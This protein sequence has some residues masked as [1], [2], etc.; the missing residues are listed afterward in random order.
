M[1][2]TLDPELLNLHGPKGGRWKSKLISEPLGRV[3]KCEFC[4]APATEVYKHNER[5]YI[6]CCGV[7]AD[8]LDRQQMVRELK[9]EGRWK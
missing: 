5:E 7:H 1:E 9:G 6:A 3:D 4:G 2:A 8:I